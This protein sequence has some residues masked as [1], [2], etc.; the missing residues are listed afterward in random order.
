MA[1]HERDVRSLLAISETCPSGEDIFF[2]ERSEDP[3]A[4]LAAADRAGTGASRMPRAGLGRGKGH[5][6]V[7]PRRG[8]LEQEKKL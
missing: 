3:T 2:F 7:R 5:E 8:R 4:C 6:A 1:T